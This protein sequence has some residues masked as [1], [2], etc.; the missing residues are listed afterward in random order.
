MTCKFW[1]WILI[2]PW[3]TFYSLTPK[4][5]ANIKMNRILNHKRNKFDKQ[6]RIF[7]TCLLCL[8]INYLLFVFWLM[9]YSTHFYSNNVTQFRI[10]CSVLFFNSLLL[11]LFFVIYLPCNQWIIGFLIRKRS[12]TV[13]VSSI[14]NCLLV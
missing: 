11:Y 13:F 7:S 5:E 4:I 2:F 3:Y 12:K 1:L 14:P 6:I 8:L 9:N 10:G